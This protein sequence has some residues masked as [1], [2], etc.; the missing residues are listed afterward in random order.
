MG[1]LG[2]KSLPMLSGVL[3]IKAQQQIQLPVKVQ[4]KHDLRGSQANIGSG[5]ESSVYRPLPNNPPITH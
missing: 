1:S 3:E 5:Q 4:F 2:Q